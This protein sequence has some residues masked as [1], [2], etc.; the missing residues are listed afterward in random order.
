[1]DSRARYF[2][3]IHALI[4]QV[5]PSEGEIKLLWYEEWWDGPLT[6]MCEWESLRYYFEFFFIPFE[7]GQDDSYGNPKRGRRYL[8]HGS[9]EALR[10]ASERQKERLRVVGDGNVY[11]DVLGKWTNR[12]SADKND[13]GWSIPGPED[14]ISME[15]LDQFD[16]GSVGWFYE[17]Q[18][19]GGTGAIDVWTD[20]QCKKLEE[21]KN[22]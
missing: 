7:N 10:I 21:M 2:E 17:N 11:S 14:P 6:G 18:T 19:T 16:G 9:E 5:P 8:L 22:R 3:R 13:S 15:N 4:K 12:G 1:M 20:E